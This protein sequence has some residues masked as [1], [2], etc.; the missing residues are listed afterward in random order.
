M[1]TATYFT[2]LQ[3]IVQKGFPAFKRCL[4]MHLLYLIASCC[5]IVPSRSFWM[6]LEMVR[7][8]PGQ[9]GSETKINGRTAHSDGRAGKFERSNT[10]YGNVHRQ[11]RE[12]RELDSKSRHQS[13]SIRKCIFVTSILSLKNSNQQRVS[14]LA[15]LPQRLC[16][17]IGL[18][19]MSKKAYLICFL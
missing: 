2:N 1:L 8:I 17:K 10:S 11:C 7:N 13:L 6:V 15:T 4:K 3:L 9:L 16:T 19:P 14:T 5:G 12:C 18:I